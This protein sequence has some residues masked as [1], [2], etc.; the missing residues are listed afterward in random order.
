MNGEGGSRREDA[1]EWDGRGKNERLEVG[2]GLV[3]DYGRD[4][5]GANLL[6]AQYV[7]YDL[8]KMFDPAYT[9]V[10]RVPRA[11]L[12]APTPSGG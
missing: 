4:Q 7:R 9:M 12:P 3:Q 2:R 6:L 11:F 5:L 1:R 10:C 8:G